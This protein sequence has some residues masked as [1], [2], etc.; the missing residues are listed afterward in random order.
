MNGGLVS[1]IGGGRVERKSGSDEGV[2]TSGL[3]GENKRF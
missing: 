1:L 2:E 3:G